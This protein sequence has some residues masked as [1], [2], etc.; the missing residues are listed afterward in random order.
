MRQGFHDFLQSIAV[1]LTM[2]NVTLQIKNTF[3]LNLWQTL[4]I[5]LLFINILLSVYKKSLNTKVSKETEDEK[6]GS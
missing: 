2:M 5:L 6:R 1:A 3:N 4:F